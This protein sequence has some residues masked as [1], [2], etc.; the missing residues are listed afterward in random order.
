MTE[1]KTATPEGRCSATGPFG[2]VQVHLELLEGLFDG[3][4]LVGP[5][6]RIVFWNRGAERITGFRALEVVGLECCEVI[7]H[8]DYRR[9]PLCPGRR[10]LVQAP[11]AAEDGVREALVY[12]Q[13]RQGRRVPVIA[14]TSM[15]HGPDGCPGVLEVFS[16][17]RLGMIRNKHLAEL[18]RLALV[19]PLTGLGNRRYGEAVLSLR[20]QECADQG[21]RVG[22]LMADLDNF[23]QINDSHGH[24][25]GDEVLCTVGR[26]FSSGLRAADTVARWGGE[27]FLF[28]LSN[29]E[30]DDLEVVAEKLRAEVESVV[31]R[32]RGCALKLTV[33]LG[34]CLLEEGDTRDSV[35]DRA[36]ARLY[37]SKRSGRNR[38]TLDA[39]SDRVEG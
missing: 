2:Q 36:D 12:I 21:T 6:G 17:S 28:I 15:V 39:A 11:Q 23:K 19:D 26:I 31:I 37:R 7:R 38:V 13:H 1:E 8:H 35:L 32:W 22:I 14:R 9:Q 24:H 5:D 20:I 25:A 18:K 4:L 10:C 33:S 16:D 30:Q 34:G 27:E 3:V 29:M